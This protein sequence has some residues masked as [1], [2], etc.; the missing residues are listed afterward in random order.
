MPRMKPGS[1]RRPRRRAGRVLAAAAAVALGAA[2]ARGDAIDDYLGAEMARRAIPGLALAVA[3]DG[4]IETRC[5]GLAHVETGSR[6]AT[7]SVFAIASLDKQLTAAGV[8]AA[9]QSGKLRL[10][11]PLARWVETPFAGVTL[12]HLLSHTAGLPDQVAGPIE[13][14]SFSDY[15]T[16]QLLA[17][18]RGLAPVAP[19]GHRF[20]YSDAGLFLA[21]LATERAA[22]E[23]WWDFVRRELF[24]PAG[25]TSPVSMAPGA[26]LPGRVSAYTLDAD[27]R[28]ARDRRLDVDFGPLYSD[29]GMTAADF[30]RWLAALDGGRPLS[31]ASAAEMTEPVRLADGSPGG[32]L[33]QW[34]RYGLGVGLDEFA[35]EPVVLHSGHSGVGFVRFPARR[36]AV[37]VFTNLEH[38]A[39]SD[40]VGLALGVAGRLEPGLDLAGRSPVAPREP[41]RAGA[42]RAAYESLLAGSAELERFAPPLRSAAWEGAGGLAGRAPRLGT[43]VRFEPI[44]E[45]TIDG[46]PSLLARAAHERGTIYVRACFDTAGR[47]KRLVWWHL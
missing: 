19:P 12:R 17:T 26:L 7:D 39:G 40:P 46:E 8:L 16:E 36:L 44:E 45:R 3:R 18:V 5:Y 22:G 9:A 20:L 28:L 11:D 30:A 29:L 1:E 42:L 43:L 14:R 27:G 35:G 47:I 34:S 15:T 37:V 4:R 10:D 24:A 2:A 33:F 41:A 21:Q 25:M 13:G 23:P 31:A 38:A 6:V 32:E